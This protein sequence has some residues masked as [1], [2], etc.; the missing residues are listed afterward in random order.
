MSIK[1][2]TLHNM[3]RT[4]MIQ[5]SKRKKRSDINE[6]PN[7]CKKSATL[8][9]ILQFIQPQIKIAKNDKLPTFMCSDCIEKLINVQEF[10]VMYKN[11]DKKFRQMLNDTNV[12]CRSETGVSD[13]WNTS[14]KPFEMD[15]IGSQE[16]KSYELEMREK[17]FEDIWKDEES[18]WPDFN[19]ESLDGGSD[20]EELF[21][22]PFSDNSEDEWLPEKSQ[23]QNCLNNNDRVD[24]TITN[25]ISEKEP[26][27]NISGDH[28]ATVEGFQLRKDLQENISKKSTEA[29]KG[30]QSV[31]GNGSIKCKKCNKELENLKLFRLHMR[32]HLLER[33]QPKEP[34]KQ[35]TKKTIKQKYYECEQCK[36]EF[37]ERARY[38]EHIR[39]HME[40]SFLC[41]ECGKKLKTASSLHSHMLRHKGEKNFH[42]NQC[43]MKFDCSSG[44]YAHKLR[45][46]KEKRHVCDV[47]GKSFVFRCDLK[48]HRLYHNGVKNF[49]CDQCD[50]KFISKQ[51][52]DRH[53]LTHTGEKPYHCRYC[54]KAFAQ[55]NDCVKHLRNH[56]GDDN[57]YQCELCPLRFPLA[58]KL[59][60][61]LF[62]HNDEDEET[63]ARNL[64][65]R[66]EEE[67]KLQIKM[68]IKC[69]DF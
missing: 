8:K 16:I 29:E 68:G 38:N 35:I 41:I 14:E 40:P 51:K 3:C 44:L 66:L 30:L 32:K 47:C 34:P 6:K 15:E 62:T 49:A 1:I 2:I 54:D 23:K 50:M 33:R 67:Q 19:D 42:C 55:S 26:Q 61:H 18:D 22:N 12:N 52:L 9:E 7:G 31:V 37:K 59:R 39:V 43:P 56:I 63:R 58:R 46:S 28:S 60:A 27:E 64:K 17:N 57:V 24:D 10:I 53:K 11:S 5:F 4:C 36:K 21:S 13:L 20:K 45:H 65:A 48:K 25:F 69:L